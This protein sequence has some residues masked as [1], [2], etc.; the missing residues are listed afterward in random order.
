MSTT[1]IYALCD[2]RTYEV[3]YIGKAD[4]PY[5]RLHA[6]HG[7]LKDKANT[8]KVH[9]IQYLA[10][11]G[12]APCLQ[13]VEQCEAS[14]WPDRERFWI[15]FYKNVCKCDLTNSTE[16]GENPPVR[17]GPPPMFGRHHSSETRRKMSLAR[18]GYRPSATTRKKL[19]DLRRGRPGPTKGKRLSQEHRKKISEA[20]LR[21][22][23]NKRT[24]K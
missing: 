13:I 15:S 24:T 6:A 3:R 5:N 16:G 21:L 9:W 10:T 17:H 23:L 19:S 1:F 8:H 2:P 4:D 20:H 18:K 11:L 22:N 12:L 7:H 14:I